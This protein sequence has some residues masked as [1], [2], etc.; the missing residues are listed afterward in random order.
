MGAFNSPQQNFLYSWALDE[1]WAGHILGIQSF[2]YG[3]DLEE[4]IALGALSQDELGHARQ[5]LMAAL[6]IS[7][8]DD[9]TLDTRI[10]GAKVEDIHTPT[11]LDLD[12]Q[13]DWSRVV[14][15]HLFYDLADSI[16]RDWWGRLA[17]TEHA[18]QLTRIMEVEE[19]EHIAHW[20]RWIVVLASHDSGRDRLNA[21][22]RD[23]YPWVG[24]FYQGTESTRMFQAISGNVEGAQSLSKQLTDQCYDTIDTVLQPLKIALPS[25]WATLPSGARTGV[26]SSLFCQMYDEATLVYRGR[27]AMRWT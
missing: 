14:V 22:V 11:L 23:Y 6:E 7:D 2:A 10:Y 25:R 24:E 15:R 9:L 1:F 5:L 21:A 18:A 17:T 16:R 4:N 20:T 3:P 13:R 12:P 27:P 26:H 8:P 19:A